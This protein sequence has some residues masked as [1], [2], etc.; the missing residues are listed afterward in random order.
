VIS[1]RRLAREW[2]LK[3]LYQSDVGKMSIGESQTAALE[4]L[5]REFVQ[6]GSRAAS[7]SLLEMYCLDAITLQLTDLLP[8]LD[9][10]LASALR[11][12]LAR[13]FDA[14][15]FWERL[16]VDV[17]FSRQSFS[18]LWEIPRQSVPVVLPRECA[19]LPPT[20]A[21]NPKISCSDRDRLQEFMGWAREAVPTAVMS[22]Y[23]RETQLD[24]PPGASLKATQEYVQERWTSFSR[25]IAE[26]WKPAAEG[27]QKQ[28]EDWV[29]V[30]SFT[31]KLVTGVH[32]HQAELDGFLQTLATGWSI[33]RQVS[34][35]RNI[36]RMA[37]F[38]LTHIESIPTS[39]T[40]NEAVELA[41]KYSTAESGRFVNGVLGAIAAQIG[42]NTE[43]TREPLDDNVL[44][45]AIDPEIDLD[46]I[47]TE[48]E[49]AHV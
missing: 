47:M 13:I 28:M 6:R 23:A 3:I 20:V 42:P 22:A 19:A 32:E 48:E 26:R 46:E 40:I 33:D 17:R 5:R 44:D 7:G 45:V 11:E 14:G 12:C 1:S 2:A 8:R 29:R 41:K 34:V 31:L 49:L 36:L 30:A 38:E 24:R 35:D 25:S 4:R 10:N 39:A 21:A 18:V 37:A 16:N 43:E 9:A 27:V 15:K